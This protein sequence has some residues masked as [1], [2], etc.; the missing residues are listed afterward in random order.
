MCQDDPR[1]LRV[2]A[3]IPDPL[4]RL[5]LSGVGRELTESVNGG[6]DLD[7][8]D[9]PDLKYPVETRLTSG[10]EAE[11]ILRVA[12]DVECDL[13]VMGTH[14]RTGLGRLLIGNTAESVLPKADCPVLVVKSPRGETAP[15]SGQA[16][17][18]LKLVF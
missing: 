15:T 5:S 12:R 13:I 9:G 18:G 10:F 14:G 2:F 1:G 16:V 6:I 4:N 8:L 3:V 11:G 17:T 7:R